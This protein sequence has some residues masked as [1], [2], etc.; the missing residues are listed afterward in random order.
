MQ[1]TFSPRGITCISPYYRIAGK[2]KLATVVVKSLLS[3]TVAG[4]PLNLLFLSGVTSI[5]HLL[6]KCDNRPTDPNNESILID[7]I[8]AKIR[9]KLP[10]IVQSSIT[11]WGPINC[12]TWYYV[13]THLRIVFVSCVSLMW[14][15]YLSYMQH[16]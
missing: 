15:S 11:F 16:S 7:D 6:H 3:V 10:S 5:E 12:I 1:Y 14:N 8:E 4:V 2:S 9:N 13:P